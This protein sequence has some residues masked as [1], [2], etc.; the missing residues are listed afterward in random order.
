[1]TK[2]E[3]SVVLSELIS[4][5]SF[6]DVGIAYNLG[7]STTTVRNAI[8]NT[9]NVSSP[10]LI[11]LF[12]ICGANLTITESEDGVDYE[13]RIKNRRITPKIKQHETKES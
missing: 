1:M 12:N 6:S 8:S 3:L 13:V 2:E 9:K 5:S 11:R 4:K 10:I 7:I